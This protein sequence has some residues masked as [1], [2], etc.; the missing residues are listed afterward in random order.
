[1]RFVRK[2]PLGTKALTAFSIAIACGYFFGAMMFTPSLPAI[3]NYFDTNSSLTRMTVSSFFITMALSQLIYGPASD[4]YGRKPIIL[5]GS[6]IF[7]LGSLSCFVSQSITFLIIS[8]AIQGFGVGAL[9]TLAKTVVQDSFTKEQFLK[10]VAWM[11]IFFSMAPAISPVIGGFFQVHFGWQASFVFM[12]IF[13]IVL[14]IFII[15]LFPETNKEK[16]H[17]AMHINHL[18]RSYLTITKNKMF[19]TYMILNISALSGGVIFDVIGS[20]ILI[21]DYH[22]TAATFGIISTLLMVVMIFSRILMS[23][24]ISSN[25]KKEIILLLGL[26]MMSSACVVLGIL[27]LSNLINLVNL[28]ILFGLFCLGCGFILPISSASALS[29]FDN[30][31]GIAGSFYGSIQMGGVFLVSIIASSLQPSIGFMLSILSILSFISLLIG[32]KTFYKQ[33]GIFNFKDKTTQLI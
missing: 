2:K 21:D 22:L 11:S 13:A 9:I 30:M 14:S 31:K 5:L 28:L 12:F 4:K 17:K 16:N 3:A 26:F 8:R 19:W 32:I 7:A 15:F 33:S 1:M 20:F 29:L 10:V 27:Y 18:I 25:I 6:I 23:A 24:L